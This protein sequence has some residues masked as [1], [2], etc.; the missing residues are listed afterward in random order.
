MTKRILICLMATASL[1]AASVHG[2]GFKPTRPVEIVVHSGLG[3]GND[4]LGRAIRAI[5]E[6]ENLVPV[7]MNVVN[8]TGGAGATAMAYMAERKG[9]AH[10]IGLYTAAWLTA[11][12]MSKEIRVQ[13]HELT[14]IANL[15]VE[16]SVIVVK[17]D[18]PY[19]TLADF[20]DAAKKT[21]DKLL[22]V[23]SSIESRANLLR[24]VLQR[25][26]G[27]RWGHVPFP[28]AGERIT[29]VLGG[30]AHIYF[31]DPPE[32][33]EHVNSGA[34]RV[35]AQI[36]DKRLPAFPNAPTIK[37]AGFTLPSIISVRGVLAPPGIPKDVADY[38]ENLFMR[39]VKTEGWRKFVLENHLE[40]HYL[41]SRE[42]G[43]LADEIVAERRQLYAEFGIK[44]AR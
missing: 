37:E 15:L 6:K 24:L 9:D 21:P 13:F 16:P 1:V 22:Q 44:T 39:M 25:Q 42:I 18:S 32:V 2:Q 4:I 17:G 33:L 30:H 5:A 10:V 11:P 31:G 36:A 29:A 41:G 8:K 35:V 28:G 14:P 19:R 7:R 27:A 38:W 43:K 3:T 20:I 12:M 40:E 34:L 23:G 26:T